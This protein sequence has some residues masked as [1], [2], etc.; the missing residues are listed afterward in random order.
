[1]KD[2]KSIKTLERTTQEILIDFNKKGYDL[3]TCEELGQLLNLS[4]KVKFAKALPE[5]EYHLS[6][7]NDGINFINELNKN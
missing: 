2:A 1:M 6:I 7:I 4:D 3:K 5:E